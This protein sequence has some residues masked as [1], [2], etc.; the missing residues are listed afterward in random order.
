MAGVAV[1]LEHTLSA[2]H[3]FLLQH[4]DFTIFP[5]ARGSV[6][7][8]DTLY[9]L[10][11]TMAKEGTLRRVLYEAECL[12]LE[13][14]VEYFTSSHALLYIATTKGAKAILGAVW[15][16]AVQGGRAQIGIW[17]AKAALGELSK[18]ITNRVL[19][20]VFTTFRWHTIWGLT[21]WK[22]AVRH[23]VSLGFKHVTTVPG[24][25]Q[26]PGVEKTMPLYIIRLENPFP[27]APDLDAVLRRV[28][29]EGGGS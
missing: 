24:F 13:Q 9:A 20:F 26:M 3:A 16:T 6:Y 27:P 7:P 21:P 10:Y 17:Y 28:T 19:C 11:W 15:F 4:T 29:H 2:P 1:D 23:G 18:D 12:D 25:V 8:P 14:F 22:G 5:Y